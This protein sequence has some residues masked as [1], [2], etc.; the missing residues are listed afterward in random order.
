MHSDPRR[1]HARA[2]PSLETDYCE[3][4][5]DDAGHLLADGAALFSGHRTVIEHP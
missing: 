2:K 4:L 1:A 3:A 5:R